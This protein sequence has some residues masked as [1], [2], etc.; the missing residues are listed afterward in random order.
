MDADPGVVARIGVDIGGTFTDTASCG[1]DGVLRV[2]KALTTPGEE[3]RGVRASIDGSGADLETAALFVHGTTLVINALLERRGARTALVATKGFGDVIALG[4]GARPEIYNPFY[5][6]EAPYVPAE[7]RF[8]LGERMNA[9]GEPVA[10]PDPAEIDALAGRL[11]EQG[12]EAVAVAFLHAYRNPAHERMVADRLSAALPGVFVTCSSD[13][14]RQ[15]REYERF[16]TAT[17]NAYVAPLIRKYA[18]RLIGDLREAGFAGD[19]LFLDAGGGAVG[20]KTIEAFPIRLVESG[21]V[22]GVIAAAR[23]AREMELDRVVTLDVGGTT[24][25]ASLIEDGRFESLREY[26]VGG[27]ARG[28]PLQIPVVDIEE[29]GAG[30]GSIAWLDDGRLRVGPRS[31]GASPGPACYGAGGTEPA[32]TDALVHCGHFHPSLFIAQIALDADA[33]TAA[34]AR[35]AARCGLGV[36]ELALGMLEIACETT[37]AVVRRQTLE[38]GL[39]PEDFT[40]IVS[41]GAGPGLACQVA[42]AVGIGRVLVPAFP[43]HFSAFGMLQSELRFTAQALVERPLAAMTVAELDGAVE[44]LRA[45]LEAL[46][47]EDTRLAGAARIEAGLAL[48]YA[49]QE[50]SLRLPLPA[51]LP[52]ED[53][54]MRARIAAE[55]R[56]I[57]LRRY[58]YVDDASPV[59]AIDLEVVLEKELP[60]VEIRETADHAAAPATSVPCLF[61]GVEGRVEA[62]AVARETVGE[63]PLAGPALIYE[64]GSITVVPPGWTACA[65]VAGRLLLTREPA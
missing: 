27:Y 1:P 42:D 15:W 4:R 36:D 54:A 34:I 2:G 59:E 19:A 32:I 7:L 9:A 47:A 52:R 62:R 39:D 12:V 14:G 64:T 51:D 41:G 61:P 33:A 38:R 35:L 20:R 21:P 60:P 46:V 5:A 10:V 28:L 37:A 6:R 29:V 24:A 26:W 13:L 17:A 3:G 49:G 31:A 23:I 25:K 58:G 55:F 40:M 57:Y 53:A 16:T 56:E 65:V 63:A 11:R 30:G 50:H 18:S 44:A 22:G 45:E 48:R 8:E 43:G